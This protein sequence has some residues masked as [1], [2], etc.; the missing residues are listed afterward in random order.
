MRAITYLTAALI[1]V[2]NQSMAFAS[3]ITTTSPDNSLTM[4]HNHQSGC[5][6]GKINGTYKTAFGISGVLYEIDCETEKGDSATFFF[7]DTQGGERCY[8]K[9]TESWGGRDGDSTEWFTL[10]AVPGY[11][12][13][14]IGKPFRQDRMR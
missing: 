7:M 14:S 11:Q 5:S 13:N 12:C 2:G 1:L 10:G 4:T 8:G 6:S 9:M 3:D